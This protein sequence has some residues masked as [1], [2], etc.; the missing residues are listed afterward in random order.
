MHTSKVISADGTSLTSANLSVA[1]TAA[2]SPDE[3]RT[4]LRQLA[5]IVCAMGGV[6]RDIVYVTIDA[7]RGRYDL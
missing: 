5:A 7:L 3:A 2:G 4:P 1:A 6:L